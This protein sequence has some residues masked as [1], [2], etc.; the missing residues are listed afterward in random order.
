MR[1]CVALCL[2]LNNFEEFSMEC[3]F[4]FMSFIAGRDVH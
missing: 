1:K 2:T 4:G 3:L